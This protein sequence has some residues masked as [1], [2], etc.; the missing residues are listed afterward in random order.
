MLS[1][2]AVGIIPAFSAVD[3][4]AVAQ[5]VQIDRAAAL[6]NSRLAL[7][8]GGR[9]AGGD[10]E[11]IV[12]ADMGEKELLRRAAQRPG[13]VGEREIEIPGIVVL[14]GAHPALPAALDTHGKEKRRGLGGKGRAGQCEQRAQ[15]KQ[16]GKQF[17]RH[18]HA[19]SSLFLKDIL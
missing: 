10:G 11:G 17:S 1:A 16:E 5:K 6:P 14:I 19:L 13:E 9:A 18:V 12:R 8:R 4:D 3:E 7:R 2:A 15:A